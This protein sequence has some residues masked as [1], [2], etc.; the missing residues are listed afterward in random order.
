[1]EFELGWEWKALVG[2]FLWWSDAARP[3][4]NE[5][6]A[7]CCCFE[8]FLHEGEHV[9]FLVCRDLVFRDVACDALAVVVAAALDLP[10]CAHLDLAF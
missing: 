10:P 8:A 7:L 9:C 6:I 4:P 1:M 2:R 5:S 3:Q